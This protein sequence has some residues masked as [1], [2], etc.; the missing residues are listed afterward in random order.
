MRLVSFGTFSLLAALALSAC[1]KPDGAGVNKSL[2]A[3]NV[4]DATDLND[5]MLTVA[6]PNEAV[7]YFK[8]ASAQDPSR[9]DF[10]RGLGV[11]LIRASRPAEA[12]LVFSKIVAHSSVN[13][14]DRIAYA[15]ALIRSGEWDR[16]E[17][18]L[19]KISPTYETYRRYRLEAMVADSNKEWKN[20]DSYYETAVGMTTKPAPVLNN[21]GYSKLTRGDFAAAERLFLEAITNDNDLFISKNNLVLS[22]VAQKKYT[23]PAIRT[24]QTEKAELLHTMALG[25]LKQGDV[26]IGRGLL[27]DAIATHPQHFSAAIRNLESLQ[28]STKS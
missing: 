9:I 23:F 12:V 4:I 11:S 25:A 17:A 6:D 5:I 14:Q 3:V 13:N 28:A 2:D 27:I 22:R 7:L 18:Q 15:D 24:T 21:W 26:D 20:A 19:D 8:Q 10:L 16:A 1:G